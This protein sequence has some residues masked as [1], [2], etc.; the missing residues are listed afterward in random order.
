MAMLRRQVGLTP[1]IPD[2]LAQGLA[3]IRT[4]MKV[5]AEFPPDVLAA[6]DAAVTNPRLPDHDLTDLA[7]ETIDPEGSRDLDQAMYLQRDGD[8]YRVH[9]AIADVAA[10]VTAGDPIDAE[11]HRRGSTF[12]APDHRT[13][14]HPPRL[15]EDA[16]SLLPDRCRPAM[17][18]DLHLDAEGRTDDF[19][20]R[21]A[22]VRSRA[23]HSYADVQ[24][25]IDGGTASESIKL[26]A[27][28]GPLREQIERERGGV[29]LEVPEQ[30]IDTSGAAWELKFRATLPVEGW[31]AQISLLTGMAA[32]RIMMYGQVGILRTL[33]SA[34]HTS[35]RKLHQTAK[36]LKINWPAE[37][38]YPEFVRSLDANQPPQAAMMNAC[39]RL[40]RG[41][42]YKAFS[43][44]IP[45]DAEHAAIA[46]EYAHCTAPLRRLVDR[47]A[48]EICAALCA[49]QPVPQWVLQ[50]LDQLPDEM[51]AAGRRASSYERAIIDL[52]EAY[53]LKPQ[54]GSELSGVIVDV[55]NDHRTGQ[56]IVEESAVEAKIIG[57][58]LSLGHQVTAKLIEADPARRLVRFELV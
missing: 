57:T 20:V 54:L 47:Y 37:C 49:D 35:L 14:L 6:A 10:F 46:S 1:P 51:D 44:G 16:A 2:E 11:A 18:W 21:R 53:L 3:R 7:F 58:R 24:A 27:E 38:D 33:P 19:A 22:M 39:T 26:L 41:A 9:Y 34:D 42:G 56:L 17:V 36:A 13:P 52:M 29:N 40:F 45:E 32:A 43:G 8:G 31:N 48:L 23:M 5:P 15:S 55:D 12:Y 25:G 30:E 50:V 28:I 4:E